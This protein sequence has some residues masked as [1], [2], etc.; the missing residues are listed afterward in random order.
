MR[1]LKM[2]DVGVTLLVAGY[3][4]SRLRRMDDDQREVV[5]WALRQ[6]LDR[7]DEPVTIDGEYVEVPG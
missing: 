6:E 1:F 2:L 5:R 3:V 4:I 7:P